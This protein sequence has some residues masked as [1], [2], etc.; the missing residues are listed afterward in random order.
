MKQEVYLVCWRSRG[1]GE[2]FP[3]ISHRLPFSHWEVIQ[4]FPVKQSLC[5]L[6][7]HQTKSRKQLQTERCEGQ[8]K[9]HVTYNAQ[10]IQCRCFI[11]LAEAVDIKH[12]L[13][14][15]CGQRQILPDDV[16]W[17]E[18]CYQ[19]T[20]DS[21]YSTDDLFWYTAIME[22]NVKICQ[23]QFPAD[24]SHAHCLDS[25]YESLKC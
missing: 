10:T 17:L 11:A 23:E 1:G 5:N 6:D 13:C 15:F 25:F 9:G 14:G 7:H 21:W 18:G 19:V 22:K 16:V 4:I 20:Y 3:V 8:I 12:S 24:S 2:L